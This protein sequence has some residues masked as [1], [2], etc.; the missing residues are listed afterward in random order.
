MIEKITV[1]TVATLGIVIAVSFVYLV[2]FVFV[3]TGG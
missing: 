3:S 1:Y 2:V